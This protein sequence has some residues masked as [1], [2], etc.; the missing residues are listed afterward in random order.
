MK[1]VYFSIEI[2]LPSSPPKAT[3]VRRQDEGMKS[4]VLN[5]YDLQLVN[6]NFDIIKT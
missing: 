6:Y 2:P 3:E 4:M 5:F 1:M